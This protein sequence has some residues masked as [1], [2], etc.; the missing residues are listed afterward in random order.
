MLIIC[1]FDGT[2]T[3]RDTNSHLAQRFAPDRYA[4]L[5]DK[6]A[7]RELSVREVLSAEFDRIGATINDLV[8]V[9]LEVPVRRGFDRLIDFVLRSESALVVLSSGF[10]QLI[11]PI[12]AREGVL[13][14]MPLLANDL[15]VVD[16]RGTV[17]WRD[18][19]QCAMCGEQCKRHDVGLLR[20]GAEHDGRQFERVVFIGDGFSDRCGAEAADV[21]FARDALA[22]WLDRRDVGWLAWD[23]FDDIVDSLERRAEEGA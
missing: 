11:E 13:G 4:L 21:I 14:A 9:A 16:G 19:P 17:A 18:L 2:I 3:A 12:L 15:Q 1:D 8:D 22:S 20:G 10:R 7:R 6:L 23:D 5:E